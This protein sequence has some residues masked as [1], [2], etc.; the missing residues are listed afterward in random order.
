M[1][2]GLSP[3]ATTRLADSVPECLTSANQQRPEIM[4]TEVALSGR[5]T[6]SGAGDSRQDLSLI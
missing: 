3:T 4:L 2:W 1:S 6:A 5:L